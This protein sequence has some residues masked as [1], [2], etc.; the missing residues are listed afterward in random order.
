MS[1]NQIEFL[2][3]LIQEIYGSISFNILEVGALP[4]ANE[5][6]PFHQ[7]LDL[8]PQSNIFAFELDEKLCD[9]LNK[10]AK[11]G[12]K[13]YPVALGRRNELS[14]LYETVHPM[15]SSLYKPNEELLS[16]YMNLEVAMIKKVSSINTQSLDSFSH[17][18]DIKEIDFI[19]ID[20]QGAELD[21]FKGGEETLKNVVAIVSEVEFIP[22]Y[23][24]QP[25]FGDICNYL[26]TTGLM[27]HKFLGM[28][29]RTL[30]PIKLNNDP[31]FPSQHMWSDA[32]FIRDIL[33]LQ[34][35]P[36][37]K[38]LKLSVLSSLYKS[39][40]VTL[41]CL[42]LLDIRNNTEINKRFLNMF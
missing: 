35:L 42:N 40:D 31:N 20:V 28:A 18:Y 19:K 15:C 7:L 23:Q 33:K 21:I 36:N 30:K 37:E 1:K 8:F 5:S 29:G 11:T 16:K 2:A 6:E 32:V 10:K 27:F 12:L 17:E 26:S 24:N 22:L 41:F 34:E 14:A 4:L 13:Y 3:E 9:D 39:Y 25:L 38:L